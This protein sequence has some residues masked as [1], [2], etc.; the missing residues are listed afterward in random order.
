MASIVDLCWMN[1]EELLEDTDLDNLYMRQI[2]VLGGD[3]SPTYPY[4]LLVHTGKITIGI[5]LGHRFEP[6]GCGEGLYDTRRA[7]D[8]VQ[9][10]VTDVKEPSE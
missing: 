3:R 8:E 9:T 2:G 10:P 1:S 4:L 5:H 7:Q 6:A